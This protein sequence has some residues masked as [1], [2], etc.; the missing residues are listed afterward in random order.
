MFPVTNYSTILNA[1]PPDPPGSP[2]IVV[3]GGETLFGIGVADAAVT[4][5]LRSGTGATSQ[6]ISVRALD[7]SEAQIRIGERFPIITATFVPGS[8]QDPDNLDPNF[9][10]PPPSFTFEDLGLSITTTPNVHGSN[11]VTLQMQAEFN[12]LAGGSVN[13]IPILVNRTLETQVRLS[14]GEAAVIAGMAIDE[15]RR[16]QATPLGLTGIQII[17][18]ILARSTRQRNATDLLILV[19]P[20]LV[21]LPASELVKELSIRFGAEERPLQAL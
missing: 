4:A 7:G 6:Q 3:G 2:Q 18:D 1:Q 20:R 17:S 13:G 14:E 10:I 15:T 8:G 5:A 11:E 9:A 12:L 16:T 19:R 21:R